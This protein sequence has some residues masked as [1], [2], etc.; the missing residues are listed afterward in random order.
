MP[1]KKKGPHYVPVERVEP[2]HY[3]ESEGQLPPVK[4]G[5]D[6]DGEDA[7]PEVSTTLLTNKLIHFDY[8]LLCIIQNFPIALS[9]VLSQCHFAFYRNY[10]IFLEMQNSSYQSS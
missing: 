1:I 10:K 5:N 6:S 4:D 3:S 2:Q 9:E 8:S 7:E